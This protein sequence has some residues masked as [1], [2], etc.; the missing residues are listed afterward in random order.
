MLIEILYKVGSAISEGFWLM[1]NFIGQS[2]ILVVTGIFKIIYYLFVVLDKITFSIF[3]DLFLKKDRGKNFNRYENTNKNIN[4]VAL[5]QESKLDAKLEI[6]PKTKSA[7]TNLRLIKSNQIDKNV[8]EKPVKKKNK[9][10]KKNNSFAYKMLRSIAKKLQPVKE[11]QTEGRKGLVE[12][13]L[14]EYEKQRKS[15]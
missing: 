6:K 5:K 10:M 12:K 4:K 14:K 7:K 11:K 15:L 9:K 3:S 2:I 1:V 13:Y 8:K